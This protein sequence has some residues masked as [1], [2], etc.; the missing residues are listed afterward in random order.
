MGERDVVLY[1]R[2]GMEEKVR[3]GMVEGEYAAL[4][5]FLGESALRFG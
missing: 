1:E 3:V 2:T 5:R 4:R